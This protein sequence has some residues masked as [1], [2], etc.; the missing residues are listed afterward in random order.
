M[1]GLPQTRELI[2][3]KVP[4]GA[5]EPDTLITDTFGNPMF[6]VLDVQHNSMGAYEAIFGDENGH[7]LCYIKRRLIT[8]YYKDGWDFCTYRPNFPGQPK[9][10][11][12]D[13]YGKS[14]YPFSFLS[15]RPLKCRY[16]YS[17]HKEDLDGMDTVLQAMHGWLGSM[18]VCCTPMVRFGKWQIDFHRESAGDPELNIDQSKNLLEVERGNDLLAALCIAYA[19]DKALC[20]PLV[21]IIG[22]Q[23]KEHMDDDDD[24]L[25]SLDPSLQPGINQGMPDRRGGAGGANPRGMDRGDTDSAAAG[26]LYD[27]DGSS[28][29]GKSDVENAGYLQNAPADADYS[30]SYNDGDSAYYGNQSY[31]SNASGSAAAPEVAGYIGNGGDDAGYYDDGQSRGTDGNSFYGESYADNTQ[32]SDYY[33]DDATYNTDADGSRRGTMS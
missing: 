16:Q 20:Q 27:Y 26:S 28:L 25:D 33:G 8:T 15:I 18:T 4:F 31:R 22:Y 11:E 23:E 24:S 7:K 30:E 14:V 9:Y 2:G 12:R 1:A 19:F 13:M 6:S 29:Y 32:R 21:T 5:W 17:V 10:K 3:L